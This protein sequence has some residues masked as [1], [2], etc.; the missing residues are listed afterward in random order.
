MATKR[1]KKT[2]ELGRPMRKY[3]LP[4]IDATPSELAKILFRT[5]PTDKPV[6]GRDYYCLDCERLVAYPETLYSDG[7]CEK[8]HKAVA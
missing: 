4:R 7:R 2:K 8:C 6:S 3:Y 1:K 5:P